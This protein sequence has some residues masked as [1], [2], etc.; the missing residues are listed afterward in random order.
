MHAVASPAAQARKFYD[1]AGDEIVAAAEATFCC[2]V[3]IAGDYR[4]CLCFVI[5]CARLGY[6]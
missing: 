2:E 5:G 3:R 1:Y 6:V 4:L